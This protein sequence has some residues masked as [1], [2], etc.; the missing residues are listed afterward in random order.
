M[1]FSA[2]NVKLTIVAILLTYLSVVVLAYLYQRNLTYF[3][4]RGTFIP[5]EWGLP[6]LETLTLQTKEGWRLR[7]W[8]SAATSPEKPTIVFM[9]GNG[10]HP[11]YRNTKV[12][13]WLDAG[14]GLLMVGYPGYGGNQG[15]AT[16]EGNYNAAR[17][18]IMAVIQKGVPESRLVLYGESLGT[19][20]AT[21]MATEFKAAGLILEAPFTSLPDAGASHYPFLPVRTMMKDRYDSLYKIGRVK[22]PLLLIHGKKDGIVPFKLGHRL[23][24]AA[25]E[26]KKAV[27]IPEAGHNDLYEWGAQ[28]AV[29]SFLADVAAH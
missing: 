1:T 23:F 20:V 3:P 6:E 25:N 15:S 11:G 8:Y 14:Y 26:P 19:G 27:F 12:R 18:A 2:D 10:V 9:Q 5:E 21:Q 28:D 17:A 7:S 4:G 29:L 16:E 13:P 22:A 24:E